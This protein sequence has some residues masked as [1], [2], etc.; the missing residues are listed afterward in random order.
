MDVVE[1]AGFQYVS[2]NVNRQMH[3]RIERGKGGGEE[4]EEAEEGEEGEER[5]ERKGN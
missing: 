5:R 2:T 3:E 1:T 4:A